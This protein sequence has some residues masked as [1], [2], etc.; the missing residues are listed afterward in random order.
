MPDA[1]SKPRVLL[2]IPN[3]DFGG[4]Q[5]SFSKISFGLQAWFDVYVGV[6]NTDSG[7][8]YP[9]GGTLLNLEVGGGA[10]PFQKALRLRERIQRLR[11]LKQQY[12]F[13]ACVSFLEGADYVNVLSKSRRG[14][15]TYIS[16]R[17]SKLF[18]VEIG[19]LMGTLRK[20]IGIPLTYALADRIITVS[21]GLREEVEG[22]P[23]N[24]APAKVHV[25]TNFYDTA[26]IRAQ[27]AAPLDAAYEAVFRQPVIINSGRLHVQKNLPGL[28]EVFAQVSKRVPAAK[29]V[30]I[31]DGGLKDEL[32]TLARTTLGLRTHDTWS[33]EPVDDSYQVYFVG[34]QD[35][36]FRFIARARVFAFTTNYEG[37]PN[38][39]AEAMV[40]GVAAISTDCPTGPRE[41]M[42]P[43]SGSPQQ[44]QG[45]AEYA[46]AGILLP[47]L[48]RPNPALAVAEW[49]RVLSEL[50]ADEAACRDLGAR[51]AARMEDYATERVFGRWEALLRSAE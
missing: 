8:A 45:A 6:F 28:L 9:Y 42:A 31:G 16:I 44:V 29:L 40:C 23:F 17:G 32:L 38:S 26:A 34:Y 46:P 35:N 41:I 13:V 39:L 48:N 30:L 24:V 25:I 51:A 19:G 27:A 33:G 5:R 43:G 15:R 36:P 22:P 4:A 20:R 14:E 3:L 11:A 37:F 18:D 12:G 47:L 10:N 50:V 2:L 21:D 1:S 49:V 7:I